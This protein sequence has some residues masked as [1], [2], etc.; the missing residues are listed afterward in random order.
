ML[1]NLFLYFLKEKTRRPD[2]FS[3]LKE[4]EDVAIYSKGCQLAVA[5]TGNYLNSNH[6]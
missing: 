5:D 6:S 4:P 3:E 2:I 1:F